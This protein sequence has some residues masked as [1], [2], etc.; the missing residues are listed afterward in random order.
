MTTEDYLLAV[1]R[2]EVT[3]QL[4]K[5]HGTVVM[6]SSHGLYRLRKAEEGG[7]TEPTPLTQMFAGYPEKMF[8]SPW[9]IRLTPIG[10]RQIGL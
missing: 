1:A 3:A 9:P 6:Q 10:R 7:L 4:F 2:G 5:R 8:A